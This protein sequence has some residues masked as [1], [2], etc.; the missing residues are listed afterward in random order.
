MREHASLSSGTELEWGG[1]GRPIFVKV[2]WC[3]EQRAKNTSI[4]ELQ[5]EKKNDLGPVAHS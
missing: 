3:S 2:K 4:S 5:V 1:E